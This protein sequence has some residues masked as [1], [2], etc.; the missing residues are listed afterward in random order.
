M[1]LILEIVPAGHEERAHH[2]SLISFPATIGRG[3]N[4]D[5]ILTDP[6]VSARHLRIDCNGETWTISD[7]GSENGTTLNGKALGTETVRSGDVLRLG[8]TDVRLYA[9]HHAVSPAQILRGADLHDAAAWLLRPLHAWGALVLA[10]LTTG[11]WAYIEIWNDQMGAVLATTGAGVLAA[12]F[13]WAGVWAAGGKLGG[14]GSRFRGHITAVSLYIIAN[15]GAWYVESYA[16]FMT[17]GR[18]AAGVSYSINA[19]L[20]FLLLSTSLA[21]ASRMTAERRHLLAAL[22]AGGMTLGAF[23]LNAVTAD[24]F[25]PQPGYNAKLEPY[26]AWLAPVSSITDIVRDNNALFESFMSTDGATGPDLPQS[27]D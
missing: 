21:L 4:N 6:F 1:R 20:L 26:L 9:P 22:L 10:L 13:I 12:V 16:D 11:L 25:D 18:A 7:V 15:A 14:G 3:Y 5:V 19:L 23:G 24:R 27:G 8:H 2:V 17:G